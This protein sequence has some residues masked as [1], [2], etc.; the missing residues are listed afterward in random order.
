MDCVATF[1]W[2][3]WQKSV[4]YAAREG[5]NKFL[6]YKVELRGVSKNG[7]ILLA[8]SKVPEFVYPTYLL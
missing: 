3:G 7:R 6:G 4:E 2:T 5:V 1:L 8:N